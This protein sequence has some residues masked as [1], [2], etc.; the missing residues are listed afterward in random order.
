M[1]WKLEKAT[2]G[3]PNLA[4]VIIIAGGLVASWVSLGKDQE[5][6]NERVERVEAVIPEVAA[7]KLGQAV[8]AERM[9]TLDESMKELKQDQKDG[10]KQILEKLDK[11]R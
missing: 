7:L 10:L 6:T 2:V 4:G 11:P 9:K 3:V 8:M 1:T 5:N